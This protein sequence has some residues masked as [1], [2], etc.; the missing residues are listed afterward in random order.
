MPASSS[1]VRVASSID[2][3]STR[4]TPLLMMDAESV[5]ETF[6]STSSSD[7]VQSSLASARLVS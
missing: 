5:A 6:V 1:A 4:S 7:W 2:S 3:A